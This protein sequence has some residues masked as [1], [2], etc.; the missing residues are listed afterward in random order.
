[1]N[2]NKQAS[3]FMPTIQSTINKRILIIDMYPWSPTMMEQCLWVNSHCIIPTHTCMNPAFLLWTGGMNWSDED[4]GWPIGANDFTEKVVLK[5][6]AETVEIWLLWRCSILSPPP[7][8][9]TTK[10]SDL[11]MSRP[12]TRNPY[13]VLSTL[14]FRLKC[15]Y[16]YI[17]IYIL[18]CKTSW[19]N[20]MQ[21]PRPS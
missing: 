5:V 11:R 10:H 14:Y 6:L 16:I 18:T 4:E 19:M 7:T 2:I 21:S 8:R 9:W 15:K 3:V 1:M 20:L 17:Y 12:R 13:P